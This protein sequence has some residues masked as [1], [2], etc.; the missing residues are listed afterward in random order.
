MNTLITLTMFVD[1]LL[2]MIFMF[3]K[4]LYPTTYQCEGMES[5]LL[6]LCSWLLI[7]VMMLNLLLFI[8]MVKG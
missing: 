8:G 5:K 7:S 3:T 4:H 1:C 2:I 6:H